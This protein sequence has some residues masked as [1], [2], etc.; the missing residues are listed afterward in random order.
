M[1]RSA[2]TMIELIF[3]IVILGIL[4]A[5]ALPRFQGVQDDAQIAAETAGIGAIR[6][7]LP[8][9]RSRALSRSDVDVN[10]TVFDEAG[11]RYYA[12][13]QQYD[14][15]RGAAVTH[16]SRGLYP[17]GLSTAAFTGNADAQLVTQVLGAAPTGAG[18]GTSALAIVLEPGGREGWTLV[19]GGNVAG[20]IGH[21]TQIKGQASRSVEDVTLKVH[22]A[23][24]WE[25]NSAAGTVSLVDD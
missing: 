23:K 11:V 25:Y 24:H 15:A 12:R 19:D 22:S 16:L 14:A 8:A 2:F 5:V 13:I 1:R 7:S 4:A 10:I 9:V 18:E 3:V 20:D 6:S 21:E 17:N